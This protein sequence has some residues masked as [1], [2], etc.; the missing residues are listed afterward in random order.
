MVGARGDG[1][2][3]G[4]EEEVCGVDEVHGKGGEREGG[5]E[6]GGGGGSR[7]DG[8]AVKVFRTVA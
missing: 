1:V 5:A 4:E 2:R 8:F 3:G 6:E 7:E